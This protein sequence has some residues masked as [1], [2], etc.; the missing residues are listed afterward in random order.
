M[1]IRTM[2]YATAAY[3]VGFLACV[4]PQASAQPL[5]DRITVNMPYTVTVGDKTL[6]PGPYV[7]QRQRNDETRI[8]LIYSGEGGM[9]FETSVRANNAQHGNGIDQTPD[10]TEIVLHHIGDNYYFDKVW[11]AG[12]TFGYDI[13]LPD[14]VI[15]REK[16]LAEVTVP[17]EA[18]ATSDAPATTPST[19]TTTATASNT[20][21]TTAP[22]S[23]TD[24]TS[25]SSASD[26]AVTP[27]PAPASDLNSQP[28]AATPAPDMTAQQTSPSTDT[29]STDMNSANRERRPASNSDDSSNSMPKT[30]AGWLAMLLSGGTLSGAGMLLRRKR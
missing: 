1:K 16:E 23:N 27:A 2:L 3:G 22:A 15:A 30:S 19:D 20:T 11:V 8:L 4:T 13:P 9:K 26:A 14:R 10:K 29:T 7:L 5:Y 12:K 21:T 18:T 25:S 17:A 6:T 28:Q 24:T